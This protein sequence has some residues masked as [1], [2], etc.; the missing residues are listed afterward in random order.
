MSGMYS[1]SWE[2]DIYKQNFGCKTSRTKTPWEIW[3]YARRHIKMFLTEG[4]VELAQDN[5]ISTLFNST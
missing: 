2:N 4:W 3:A 5:P 1:M